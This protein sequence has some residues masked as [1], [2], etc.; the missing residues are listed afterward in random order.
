MDRRDFLKTVLLTPAITSSLLGKESLDLG[1]KIYLLS[2]EPE[3]YLPYLLKKLEF[4][5]A[6]RPSAY[7]FLSPHPRENKIVTALEQLGWRKDPARSNLRIG[8]S[9]LQKPAF[10]S[11]TLIDKGRIVDIRNYGLKKTWEKMARSQAS[12]LTVAHLPGR[13]VINQP[14]EKAIVWINGEMVD[15]ISLLASTIKK[16][17][18]RLGQIVLQIKNGSASV[19]HSGCRHQICLTSPPIHITGE[20]IICAPNRFV[21]EIQGRTGI[22]DTIIG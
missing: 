20:R 10:A 22:L 8:F 11:F 12:L 15:Q 18:T 21:V 7:S 17:P 6:G 13:S 9:T 3:I 1:K 16:Y 2:D 14:G 5:L 4:T 19:I